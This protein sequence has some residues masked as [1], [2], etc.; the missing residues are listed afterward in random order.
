VVMP[1]SAS[2]VVFPANDS[3]AN[4]PPVVT[5]TIITP[6]KRMTPTDS[7]WALAPSIEIHAFYEIIIYCHIFI[8]LYYVRN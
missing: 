3:S 1:I 6:T 7:D 8:L 5:V 2:G 4:I